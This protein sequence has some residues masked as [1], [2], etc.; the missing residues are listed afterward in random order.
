[1]D[2]R[3]ALQNGY[4]LRLKSRNNGTLTVYISRELGRGGSCIVYEAYY[5]ASNNDR[6][7]VRL[8]ECCPVGLEI[9]RSAD[10]SLLVPQMS[11]SHFREACERM[12]HDFHT[13]TGLY[14]KDS[15]YDS[16]VSNPEFYTACG[17][18]Y[19]LHAYG[20]ESTLADRQPETLQGCIGIAARTAKAILIL[21][22]AGYLYLDCKPENILYIYGQTERVQ[23]FDLNSLIRLD[24]LQADRCTPPER[25]SFTPDYAAPELALGKISHIGP[26][27]DVYSLGALL[28]WLLFHRAPNA[29]DGSPD[30]VYSFQDMVF[31]HPAASDPPTPKP[32][33]RAR[34]TVL[35][36][37]DVLLRKL[38][39]FFHKTLAPYYGSRLQD[40]RAVIQT[41]EEMEPLAD[42]KAPF[43]R[44]SHID[45]P[46]V[47]LG[48]NRELHALDDWLSDRA[49]A[50]LWITGAGGL[51]KTALVQNFASR[52]RKKIDNLVFLSTGDS[53]EEAIADDW[54]VRIENLRRASSETLSEYALRKLSLLQK[55]ANES[56]SISLFVV[57][58]LPAAE[59]IPQDLLSH[60]SQL[61]WKV[62][63]I[64]HDRPLTYTGAALE[65]QG[66]EPA[67]GKE[68][69]IRSI[70]WDS[71][72]IGKESPGIDAIADLSGGNPFLLKLMA[73]QLREERM[74][75]ATAVSLMRGG[76]GESS[77]IHPED[78]LVSSLQRILHAESLSKEE[79][80]LLHLLRLFP[81]SGIEVRF[82]QAMARRSFDAQL[83]SLL[84]DGWIRFQNGR[85][86]LTSL[87]GPIIDAIALTEQDVSAITAVLR[88]LEGYLSCADEALLVPEEFFPV[89]RRQS[90]EDSSWPETAALPGI[91]PSEV[92]SCAMQ[93]LQALQS[94]SL[95]SDKAYLDLLFH[96][97]LLLPAGEERKVRDWSLLFLNRKSPGLYS[98]LGDRAASLGCR[99][100]DF[101]DGIPA[102]LADLFV[103]DFAVY[104]CFRICDEKTAS[105]MADLIRPVLNS[106]FHI[107]GDPAGTWT[108][109]AK[110]L[111]CHILSG[112]DDE[113]L[114][115][116]YAPN[117][118]DHSAIR[119]HMLS[120]NEM[121]IAFAEKSKKLDGGRMLAASLCTAASDILRFYQ[122][123][124]DR[125][126][127]SRIR[128]SVSL[129]ADRVKVRILMQRAE[130]YV[131][132][133]KAEDK[134]LQMWVL[135]NQ[136]W[137]Y[138]VMDRNYQMAYDYLRRSY[139][140]TDFDM[141]GPSFVSVADID[142]W[143][144]PAADINRTFHR[145]GAAIRILE[146]GIDLC[147]EKPGIAPFERK[148]KELTD[149]IEDCIAEEE[150]FEKT[151][152]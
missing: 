145:Y 140:L 126:G 93:V 66:L 86:F 72:R 144:V 67:A 110:A 84:H 65:L 54:Q 89:L 92:V 9:N 135:L 62:I 91:E 15:A 99:N 105:W 32:D 13:L 82:L 3:T 29:R 100:R 34:E 55:T 83:S 11:A 58:N 120:Y 143:I 30:A 12:K 47:F 14:Y 119:K 59:T 102:A 123:P 22:D 10:G 70:G 142:S 118:H 45:A 38:T 7:Y 50:L 133:G 64:S 94:G 78:G 108:A 77:S 16:F 61:G 51:G 148:I 127:F 25:I 137:Y 122:F 80:R 103:I 114:N 63:L 21:H 139:K 52:Q 125:H 24:A 46:E 96:T 111:A 112:I 87:C 2:T 101:I 17:T 129:S 41:L 56:D 74:T 147:R 26:W 48:R 134:D 75:V 27:T 57:D 33:S 18:I 40:M 124:G 69:L 6:K 132:F 107:P 109:Y 49:H 79:I 149:C 121:G 146:Q 138:T 60:L 104:A 37:S 106:T 150:Y 151:G 36:W 28:F 4:E 85:V 131:G 152:R 128:S 42:E 98:G 141:K 97:I 76:K 1:M 8:K 136:A 73:N 5:L 113:L 19:S 68:L 95:S 116:D 44:S 117:S 88:S 31:L 71:V 115:G 39:A 43:L 130:K 35:P 90:G 23:L 20:S 81:S 53:L